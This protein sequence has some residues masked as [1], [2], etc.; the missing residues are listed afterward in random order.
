[1]NSLFAEYILD[2]LLMDPELLSILI[3]YGIEVGDDGLLELL[4][5]SD[6]NL[7]YDDFE[8]S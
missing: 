6:F 2:S 8:T 1:M 3:E 4:Y 7:V 5:N